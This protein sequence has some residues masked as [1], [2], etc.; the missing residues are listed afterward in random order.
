MKHFI[1]LLCCLL[2]S[3]QLWAQKTYTSS[4]KKAIKLF[5]QSESALF[6]RDFD[7]A[8]DLLTKALDKDP[9]FAEA[10]LR[11]AGAYR[12]LLKSS[13]AEYHYEQIIRI[14]PQDP[15][16]IGAYFALAEILLRKGEYERAYEYANIFNE[17]ARP[18]DQRVKSDVAK[19]LTS[20]DFARKAVQNPLPFQPEPLPD[21]LNSFAMQYFPVL[22]I[23]QNTLIFTR[24]VGN[25]SIDDEDI[26]I[27][28]RKD[29]NSAWSEP[30]SISPK[31]NSVYNEGTT[32]I[33]AD[34]RTLI[35]TSCH[36]RPSFGSCDLYISFKIGN[37]WT[38]PENMGANINTGAWESQPS[39]SS[40]GRTLFFVSDRKGGF[41]RRDIYM[42]RMDNNNKW[43][44]AWNVGKEINTPD[45]EISP[46]IHFNG[47]ILY[48][49]SNGH[50]GMGGFDLFEASWKDEKWTD[51]K[52]LGFPINDHND[53]VS[54]FVSADGTRGY[55]SHEY[56]R[57]GQ[58][59]RTELYTFEIP[60]VLRVKNRSNYIFGKVLDA[61]TRKPLRASIEL[62]DLN[63]NAIAGFSYSDQETGDYLMALTEGAEY[64]LFVERVN[65]LFQSYTFNYADSQAMQAVEKDILLQ[66]VRKG[67]VTIL[68][69]IFFPTDSYELEERSVPELQ[70]VILFL[71][72]NPRIRIQI[73]GHTDNVG[74]AEYNMQLSLN[75]A[76]AVFDYLI[77][78]GV[79]RHRVRYKGFGMDRPIASNDT[80]EGKSQ[81]R[82][83]EFE[84]FD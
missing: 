69:N 49:S 74:A 33:S 76:K 62:K 26:M 47:Q 80:N 1:F 64:G 71:Q 48:F 16:L 50:P 70:K 6:Q 67:A 78:E 59:E 35:F 10:H 18:S 31:I 13:R 30:E 29:G 36:G 55:Y 83:I 20:A 37:E 5:E 82:R 54:L 72:Q 12:T 2:L 38:E 63:K 17:I 24:R 43:L 27:S 57:D 14:A 79:P 45:D 8:I 39:L 65:Y 15:K 28:K 34:G 58:R 68:N 25:R 21:P 11:L 84:L 9:N 32:A 75:R 81:N 52:N 56:A 40:D 19:L 22:T 77:R 66:P 7:L 73:N 53:Q 4:N 46:F 41:G 3:S 42:S 44:P 23:D 51:V 60:P 61:E